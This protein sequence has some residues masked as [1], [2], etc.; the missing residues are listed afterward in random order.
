MYRGGGGRRIKK[1]VEGRGRKRIG[2]YD[3][4]QDEKKH[5]NNEAPREKGGYHAGDVRFGEEKFL[6][7]RRK[8]GPCQKMENGSGQEKLHAKV[9]KSPSS[10]TPPKI[11]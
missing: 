4:Q 3:C 5:E 9:S 1:V 6:G 11:R 2:V 10:K 8:G 7:G